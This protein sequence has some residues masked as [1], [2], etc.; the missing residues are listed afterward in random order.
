MGSVHSYHYPVRAELCVGKHPLGKCKIFVQD[1]VVSIQSY[2]GIRFM[3]FSFVIITREMLQNLTI[4]ARNAFLKSVNTI[5][6]FNRRRSAAV[7]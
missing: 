6:N 2:P 3:I 4:T 7:L 5:N 1:L